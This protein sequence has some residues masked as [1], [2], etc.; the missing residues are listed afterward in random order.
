MTPCDA[1]CTDYISDCMLALAHVSEALMPIMFLGVQALCSSYMVLS[2][3]RGDR[4][5]LVIM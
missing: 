2:W 3:A 5:R 4:L 1:V